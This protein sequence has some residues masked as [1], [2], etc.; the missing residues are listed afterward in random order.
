MLCEAQEHFS[1]QYLQLACWNKAGAWGWGGEGLR[2]STNFAVA[3]ILQV[4][5]SITHFYEFFQLDYGLHWFKKELPS[6]NHWVN[7]KYYHSSGSATDSA[8]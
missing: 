6:L 1:L 4:H 7:R 8:V 5:A 3:L 2:V